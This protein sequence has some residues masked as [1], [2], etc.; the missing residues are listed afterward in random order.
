M[1]ESDKNKEV[2]KTEGAAGWLSFL[3]RCIKISFLDTL[4]RNECHRECD[5]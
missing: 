2:G 4:K 1:E 3:V 5:G